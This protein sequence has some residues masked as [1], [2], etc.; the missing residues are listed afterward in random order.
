MND[1]DDE[2]CE[3]LWI[4]FPASLRVDE[5]ILRKAFAPFGEIEKITSFPGRSY[6]FV[7]YRDANAA[8]RA[9][10]TLQ[11]KLFGN[12]RVHICYSKSDSSSSH[13]GRSSSN[14]PLSPATYLNYNAPPRIPSNHDERSFPS[15]LGDPTMRSPNFLPNGEHGHPDDFSYNRGGSFW[16]TG[17]S[18]L[19]KRK[20][21]DME[22]DLRFS[23]DKYERF[24]EDKYE[25]R[26]SPIMAR[27]P[28]FLGYSPRQNSER[29][30]LYEEPWDAP[31]EK[32]SFHGSKKSKPDSY[33]SEKELPEYPLSGFDYGKS[34]GSRGMFPDLSHPPI[35]RPSDTSGSFG[36]RQN[37]DHYFNTSTHHQEGR[38]KLPY[39]SF[40]SINGN[41]PP[42]SLGHNTFN[43]EPHLVSQK[44][45]KWEG[46]IAKSGAPV[47]RARCFPVGKIMDNSL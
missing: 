20:F 42:S 44:E 36:Y 40:Q 37:S 14:V 47:C 17:N 33:S 2:P 1:K 35:N 11:G 45:W 8:C 4:G 43:P 24:S 5:T 10:E 18:A 19:E 9:K 23:E 21:S 16:T 34:G 6:A 26:R 41:M 3:V 15:I 29:I 27:D 13:G 32:Y 12:P 7:R 38:N 25:R 46:T 30:P 31:E 22:S 28:K 39:D